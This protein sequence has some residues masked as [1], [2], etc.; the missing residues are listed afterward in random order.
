M[1][2][3]LQLPQEILDLDRAAQLIPDAIYLKDIHGIYVGCNALFLTLLKLQ[4]RTALI[5]KA[6]F[7]M[8]WKERAE[9]I[10]E[11]DDKVLKIGL[12]IE[13]EESL[14]LP[15][16]EKVVVLVRKIP[17][18]N[19]QNQIVGLVATLTDLSEHKKLEV[20]LEKSRQESEV[21]QVRI[22]QRIQAMIDTIADNHW[23]KDKEGRYLGC[24]MSAAKGSGLSSP[25]EV[26]GKTDYEL[27]WSQTADVLV[28]HDKEVME[29][30]KVIKKEEV[31]CPRGGEPRDFLVTKA[32]LRDYDVPIIGTIGTSVDITEMKQLQKSLAEAKER[33]EWL[34]NMKTQ[35]IMN[36]QHDFRTP[37]S[38]I[39]G[40]SEILKAG[41]T[42]TTKKEYL[43]DIIACVKELMEYCTKIL[44][45]SE[46][47][48]GSFGIQDKKFNLVELIEKVISVE[49]PAIKNKNLTLSVEIDENLPKLLRGDDRRIYQILINLMSNAIKFTHER[50]IKLA[51]Q[52]I[53]KNSQNNQVTVRFTIEDTGIGI[54]S[55]KLDLLYEKFNRLT[56]SNQGIYK[57]IGLGL[58][59][60]KQMVEE[61]NGEIDIESQEDKGTQF[62]CT[63]P[64]KIP[65]NTL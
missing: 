10:L 37:F 21:A 45:Y 24:S 65:L 22:E 16:E 14:D 55:D 33:A 6:D 1:D 32:P 29:F 39:L 61:I 3:Q 35:F 40:L 41:E 60:V 44:Y 51:V 9:K 20:M 4:T 15:N 17:L 27:P 46:L 25:K 43:D 7:D 5:G 50:G 56:P 26:I 63:F 42:D 13:A 12:F 64:L 34:N 38:S 62:H 19:S 36:M 53:N 18:R 28:A 52:S 30:G 59:M 2:T 8:P 47:E 48:A 58:K 49:Q 11:S 23:W 54:P 31:I 57:G